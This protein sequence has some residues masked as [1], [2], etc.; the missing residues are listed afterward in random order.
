MRMEAIMSAQSSLSTSAEGEAAQELVVY[1]SYS[2]CTAPCGKVP[3]SLSPLSSLPAS[4][5][6]L[7]KRGLGPVVAARNAPTRGAFLT[8]E[9]PSALQPLAS[10]FTMCKEW[11]GKKG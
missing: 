5:K 1:K 7:T 2:L 6:K 4:S 10:T 3:M 8:L 9:L 11:S